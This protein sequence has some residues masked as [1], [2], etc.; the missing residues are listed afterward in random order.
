MEGS[1]VKRQTGSERDPVRSIR[2]GS[3]HPHRRLYCGK[4]VTTTNTQTDELNLDW[5]SI[6]P[7]PE[8]KPKPEPEMRLTGE[9]AGGG[10][11][12]VP[13]WGAA[14]GGS[15]FVSGS[16]GDDEQRRR[17]ETQ[18][19]NAGHKADVRAVGLH[20]DGWQAGRKKRFPSPARDETGACVDGWDKK[21]DG[22][23]VGCIAAAA[24]ARPSGLL[25]RRVAACAAAAEEEEKRSTCEKGQADRQALRRQSIF[26]VDSRLVGACSKQH[27]FLASDSAAD[28][29][30]CE[31]EVQ[32]ADKRLDD[33]QPSQPASQ[34]AQ[35]RAPLFAPPAPRTRLDWTLCFVTG[36]ADPEAVPL[37]RSPALT[38]TSTL[39]HSVLL[40]DAM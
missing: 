26:P 4:E 36:S 24:H 10:G 22:G 37:A 32:Q 38:P 2:P 21:K 18:S 14:D 17:N 23:G 28:R 25:C 29:Q 1:Q 30:T 13:R 31:L 27:K 5:R 16:V 6:E 40:S 35:S 7:E 34:P 9:Q 3:I 33:K 20:H 15:G 12:G 11:G 39:S 8:P 19:I